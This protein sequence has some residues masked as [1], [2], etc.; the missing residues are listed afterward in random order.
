MRNLH[1]ILTVLVITMLIVPFTSGISTNAAEE[2]ED[3][4]VLIVTAETPEEHIKVAE[5]YEVQA[6]QMEKMS[7]MHESMGESYAKRSK[8]MSGMTQHCSKL[9]NES[10]ESAEQYRAMAKEHEKMAH[11]LMNHDSHEH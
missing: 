4:L 9:S 7:K 2:E 10:M 8:P 6:N 3:I 1:L 11:E 5:Y